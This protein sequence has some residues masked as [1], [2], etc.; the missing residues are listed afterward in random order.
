[1]V[2]D[3]RLLTSRS[4]PLRVVMIGGCDWGIDSHDDVFPESGLLS[5][6][7]VVKDSE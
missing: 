4:G 6:E 2:E 5:G 7:T 1:M 3:R